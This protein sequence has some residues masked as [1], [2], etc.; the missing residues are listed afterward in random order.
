MA[1]F[2]HFGSILEEFSFNENLKIG[3]LPVSLDASKWHEGI[4]KSPDAITKASVT[5]YF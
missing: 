5:M 1:E 3:I 2:H 4:H